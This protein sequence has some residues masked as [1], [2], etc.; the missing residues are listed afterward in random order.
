MSVAVSN[1]RYAQAVFQIAKD[2]SKLEEWQSDLRKIAALMQCP[3]FSTI[4]ENPKVPF[5]LKAKF[6][7]ETL[8]EI[9]PLALNLVYLLITKNKLSSANQIFEEYE[10]LL[11]DYHNIKRA[12]VTTAVPLDDPDKKKLGQHLETIIGS[13]ASIEFSVDPA[14]L[15]GIVARFNGS[16][17]DGSIRN[18]LE[19][20][21]KSMVEN[22]K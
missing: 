7:Q 22:R 3:E 12:K 20:L 19:A 15:G 17:I 21:K 9:N 16:L 11:D 2:T 1:K 18:K 8:D 6:T 10:H 5:E 4:L 14:I 13:K